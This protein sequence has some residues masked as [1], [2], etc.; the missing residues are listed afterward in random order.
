MPNLFSE[1]FERDSVASLN[2]LIQNIHLVNKAYGSW[3]F[4]ILVKQ[5]ASRRSFK[6]ERVVDAFKQ[7]KVF[8]LDF[9]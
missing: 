5:G 3:I 7:I 9:N 6:L 8:F 1:E 4:S 2:R